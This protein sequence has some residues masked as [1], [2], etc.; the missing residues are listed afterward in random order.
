MRL[1]AYLGG[2]LQNI[3][4]EP[5][6]IPGVEVHVHMLY[7]LSRTV[8]IAALVEKGEDRSIEMDEGAG[9]GLGSEAKY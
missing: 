3:G 8:A 9:T 6:L 5:I 4:C 7:K 1:H 2:V